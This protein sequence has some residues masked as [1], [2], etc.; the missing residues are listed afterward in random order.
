MTQKRTIET[1]ESVQ[2]GTA[3]FMQPSG[4]RIPG[5]RSGY[6]PFQ[7]AN[8]P[9]SDFNNFVLEQCTN[10][11]N[12]SFT[13][14]AF[15]SNIPEGSLN[16][17]KSNLISEI[18]KNPEF[19]TGITNKA[20]QQVMDY[21]YVPFD[22]KSF[23]EKARNDNSVEFKQLH[24]AITHH[25]NDI[26]TNK[27]PSFNNQFTELA[28]PLMG[29]ISDHSL[30]HFIRNNMA[31]DSTASI[32]AD[33]FAGTCVEK[34]I[35]LARAGK[36]IFATFVLA[37]SLLRSQN[38]M[39]RYGLPLSYS[40]M[41]RI[42]INNRMFQGNELHKLLKFDN[43][44]FSMTG[45][46]RPGRRDYET[47]YYAERSIVES[48]STTGV[49]YDEY[50]R[51]MAYNQI[52]QFCDTVSR[53]TDAVLDLDTNMRIAD[54]I[55]FAQE[56]KGN[57]LLGSCRNTDPRL[58]FAYINQTIREQPHVLDQAIAQAQKQCNHTQKSRSM[59]MSR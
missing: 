53:K 38:N 39:E 45:G 20:Y 11:I 52:R 3:F 58:Y 59:A 1:I 28:H 9:M 42:T 22:K 35:K 41:D 57:S 49:N 14:C 18:N 21:H 10:A 46:T 47:A 36:R 16:T 30:Q 27:K 12:A 26:Y 17:F 8:V 6:I 54:N 15:R 2:N 5:A 24:S 29:R 37:G 48:T 50:R 55:I 40:D 7:S 4:T 25:V 43:A 23:I 44:P 19:I 51:D 34:A 31:Q 56:R 13:N 33:V 32:L